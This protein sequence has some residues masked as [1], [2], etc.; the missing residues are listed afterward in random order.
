MPVAASISIYWSALFAAMLAGVGVIVF[1]MVRRRGWWWK[2]LLALGL[3][4][5]PYSAD[6][7]R[8]RVAAGESIV[9][10]ALPTSMLLQFMEPDTNWP[11]GAVFDRLHRAPQRHAMWDWQLDAL[12]HWCGR[13]VAS[14]DS[15]MAK[16]GVQIAATLTGRGCDESIDPLAQALIHKDAAIAGIACD[17]LT[18]AGSRAARSRALIE[19][20]AD[21]APLAE[22][23]SR[24]AAILAALPA[25]AR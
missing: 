9:S 8:S 19:S 18:G 12:A 15:A 2:L 17:A 22:T 10:A 14:N 5:G 21:H 3:I 11:Y 23:R 7:V 4:F 6:A 20:A 1:A 13:C 25:A 24:A 16:R